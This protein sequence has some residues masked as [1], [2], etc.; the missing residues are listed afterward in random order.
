MAR[1]PLSPCLPGQALACPRRESGLCCRTAIAITTDQVLDPIRT[2]TP[3][4]RLYV[5]ERVVHEMAAEVTPA[6]PPTAAA[7]WADESDAEFETFQASVRRL[8]ANDVWRTGDAEGN[9]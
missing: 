9:R 1:A 2:L 6:P 7:I 4:E 5:V 3:A 8:R